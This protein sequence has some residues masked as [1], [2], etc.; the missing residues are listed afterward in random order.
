MLVYNLYRKTS[1]LI[2]FILIL[3]S[4]SGCYTTPEIM[5]KRPWY[6]IISNDE[7]INIQSTC[8]IKVAGENTFLLGDDFLINEETKDVLCKILKR[9]GFVI[10]D[11]FGE[12]RMMFSYMTLKEKYNENISIGTQ[13]FMYRSLTS[14]YS[15]YGVNIAIILN[16]AIIKNQSVEITSEDVIYNHTI[17]L[18]IYNKTNEIIWKGESNWYSYNLDI[19]DEINLPIKLIISSLPDQQDNIINVNKVNENRTLD[20]Y[21]VFCDNRWFNCPAIPYRIKF[22]SLSSS[23]GVK[24]HSLPNAIKNP[25]ALE[26]YLDLVNYA[27]F[28]LPTGSSNY[29][30]PI[31]IDLWRKAK[32]A[33]KYCLGNDNDPVCIIIE[34]VGHTYG[35]E[36][37]KCSIVSESEFN[38][39]QVKMNQWK[40]RLK[41]FFDFYSEKAPE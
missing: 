3:L 1:L 12:Y 8:S 21:Q 24:A 37:D 5:A 32:L 27:E 10:I 28:A 26:A 36:I 13:Q 6:R 30:D 38:D 17:S 16:Q 7:V 41:D 2:L 25:E 4:I 35:Y 31:D 22:P 18:E 34:L 20:Y 33:G 40:K 11:H 29:D 9:R 39:F 14:D 19:L 15:G 23:R